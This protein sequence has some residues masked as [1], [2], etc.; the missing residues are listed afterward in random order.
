MCG[1]EGSG[2][3]CAHVEIREQFISQFSSLMMWILGIE[4]R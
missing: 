2:C 4:L 3:H 1:V